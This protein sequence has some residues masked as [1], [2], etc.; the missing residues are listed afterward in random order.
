LLKFDKLIDKD[1]ANLDSFVIYMCVEGSFT[2]NFDA[3][4]ML[5]RKGETILLP[6]VIESCQLEPDGTCTILEIYL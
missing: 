3:G 2:L 1:Y 6:A 5:V 4:T